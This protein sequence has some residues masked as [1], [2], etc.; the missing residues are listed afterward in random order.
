MRFDEPKMSIISITGNYEAIEVFAV[1]TAYVVM[2]SFLLS[3]KCGEISIWLLAILF[4]ACR[5]GNLEVV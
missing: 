5:L 3:E 2:S 4:E 1:T